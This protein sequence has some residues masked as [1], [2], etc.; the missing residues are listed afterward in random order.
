MQK[1]SSY[2]K[3]IYN[4]RRSTKEHEYFQM[5]KLNRSHSGRTKALKVYKEGL[6][7]RG[8]DCDTNYAKKKEAAM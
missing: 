8:T 6:I 4:E 7:L 1:K 5:E 3:H 2:K